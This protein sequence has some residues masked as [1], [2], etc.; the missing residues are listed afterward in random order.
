VVNSVVLLQTSKLECSNPCE[1]NGPGMHCDPNAYCLLI[2]ETSDFKCECKPG[3]NGTGKVCRGMVDKVLLIHKEANKF[4]C[5]S[6]FSVYMKCN[7]INCSQMY[8]LATV[9]MR[10]LV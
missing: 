1:M 5:Y 6:F 2:P 10:E 7:M 3:Y 4:L 8:V 9:T